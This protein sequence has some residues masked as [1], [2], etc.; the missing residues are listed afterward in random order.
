MNE[1]FVKAQTEGKVE[2]L[3]MVIQKCDLANQGYDI[4]TTEI[5]LYWE[6]LFSIYKKIVDESPSE[7]IESTWPYFEP[8]HQV[9]GTQGG[10]KIAVSDH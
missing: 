3:W 8:I 1:R 2:S 10:K 4:S 9:F 6:Y 7:N 5:I